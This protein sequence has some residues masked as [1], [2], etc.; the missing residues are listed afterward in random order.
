L[1]TKLREVD[2][3]NMKPRFDG[4]WLVFLGAL[5]WSTNAPLIKWL[6]M[7]AFLLSGMRALVA[8]LLLLPALRP[9][10]LLFNG[11]TVLMLVSFCAISLSIVFGLR[12]TSAPIA[13]GMQYTSPLWLYGLCFVKGPRPVPAKLIP[14]G[15]LLAGVVMFMFSS[16]EG[17]TLT[18]NLIALSTSFTFAA[19]T[20]STKK[21]SAENP[22]GGVALCCLFMAFFV[23]AFLPPKL[24]DIGAIP[25]DQWPIILF[26]GA[27]QTGAG[28]ALYNTGLKYT[29]PQKAAML[30]PCEMVLGPLWVALFLR[31]YPQP[32]A[33]AGFALILC[34]IVCDLWIDRA[35]ARRTALQETQPTLIP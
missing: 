10:K 4:A 6:T 12:M 32:V 22:L 31:E 13:V 20:V 3:L 11:Y 28:Y 30:S 23:F 24:S 35:I 1:N 16:G 21:V 29:T 25:A 17:V 26:L 18:G 9:R 5:L 7:D 33:L 2:N 8:G 14:L 27:C 34:G 15:L 19:L